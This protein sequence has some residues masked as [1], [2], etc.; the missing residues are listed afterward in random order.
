M[1]N[2]ANNTDSP[3][4]PVAHRSDDLWA[5]CSKMILQ[6]PSLGKEVCSLEMVNSANNTDSPIGPVAHC[7]DDL[8]AR[9]NQ[10]K[11]YYSCLVCG[12]K[13]A[14]LKWLILPTTPTHPLDLLHI[15]AMTSGLSV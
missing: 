6:L 10:Q 1:V 5:R 14:I 15:A 3:I 8:W 7:S 11:I 9:C 13:Y 12:K 4:G 2:S